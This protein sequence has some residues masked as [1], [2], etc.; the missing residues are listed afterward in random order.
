MLE[1]IGNKLIETRGYEGLLFDVLASSDWETSN[2][3]LDG[4]R[5]ID[6]LQTVRATYRQVHSYYLEVPEHTRYKR[7]LDREGITESSEHL[8][9]FRSYANAPVER[10]VFLMRGHVDYVLDADKPLDLLV[11]EVMQALVADLT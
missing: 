5:H 10:N 11:D 6:M 8:R 9:R 2:V 4:V 1:E 7:W 3:V